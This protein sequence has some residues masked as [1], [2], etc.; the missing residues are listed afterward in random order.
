M[1]HIAMLNICGY[2]VLYIYIYNGQ[3]ARWL[4]FQDTTLQTGRSR[5]RFT[6]V[7]LQFFI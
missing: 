5:V 1:L 3:G 4:S 2:F 6:M 7:S